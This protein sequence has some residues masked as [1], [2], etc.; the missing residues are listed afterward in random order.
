M[1]IL[2]TALQEF[3]SGE[4]V[5][6][7]QQYQVYIR[8]VKKAGI[9]LS[10]VEM[11]ILIALNDD[12]ICLEEILTA[13]D[14]YIKRENRNTHSVCNIFLCSPKGGIYLYETI[15]NEKAWRS[16][17]RKKRLCVINAD[18][19]TI[20]LKPGHIMNKVFTE[21]VRFLMEAARS[22]PR[23][24]WDREMRNVFEVCVA[25]MRR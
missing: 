4:E 22:A 16:N 1:S 7:N 18:N 24:A 25:A 6:K 12:A 23:E 9:W 5:S 17:K 8:E 19:G 11:Y 20:C 3:I 21:R 14:D 15:L 10:R 2:L 13:I